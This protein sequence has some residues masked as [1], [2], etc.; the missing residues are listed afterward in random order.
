MMPCAATPFFP[1]RASSCPKPPTRAAADA[2]TARKV[3]A[4]VCVSGLRTAGAHACARACA[5]MHAHRE[6][7][8]AQKCSAARLLE[9]DSK[10]GD[11]S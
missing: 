6:R 5:H 9:G 11:K 3:L 2:R 4:S 8:L 1:C 10:C 7:A